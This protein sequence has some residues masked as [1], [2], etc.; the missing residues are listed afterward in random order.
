MRLKV[1]ADVLDL[2]ACCA[3][4]HFLRPRK[5]TGR[6]Q[7][8]S[9]GAADDVDEMVQAVKSALQS[10]CGQVVLPPTALN[11]TALEIRTIKCPVP[12]ITTVHLPAALH[13]YHARDLTCAGS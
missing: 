3:T 6:Q 10:C 2:G 12:C 9:A 7:S 11:P 8:S 4:Q 1:Y 13:R 5:R